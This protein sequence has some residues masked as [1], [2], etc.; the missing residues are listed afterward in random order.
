MFGWQF[1]LLE[2]KG[3]RFVDILVF[4]YAISGSEV[5]EK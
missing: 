2:C 1:V 3:E 5:Y 4:P